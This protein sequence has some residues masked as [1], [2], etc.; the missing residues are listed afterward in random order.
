MLNIC[1]KSLV[2]AGC[3]YKSLINEDDLYQSSIKIC[4]LTMML[5]ISRKSLVLAGCFY[6]SLINEDDLYQSSIKICLPILINLYKKSL[7][8]NQPEGRNEKHW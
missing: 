2:L 4:L 5:N 1:R 8:L 3:F 6:K 7:S